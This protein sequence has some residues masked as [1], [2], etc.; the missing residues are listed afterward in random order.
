MRPLACYCCKLS[1]AW[2]SWMFN[3]ASLARCSCRLLDV[4]ATGPSRG[5][6]LTHTPSAAEPDG[7]SGESGEHL[8]AGAPPIM[9]TCLSTGSPRTADAAG[10]RTYRHNYE[11]LFSHRIL[12]RCARSS[13]YVAS[14]LHPLVAVPVQPLQ[15]PC[16]LHFLLPLRCAPRV[17]RSLALSA[18]ACPRR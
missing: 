18:R 15:R 4:A 16:S 5:F 2:P 11:P 9:H 17:P 3:S 14:L 10:L 8:R 1:D 13:P 6:A 7:E 12:F